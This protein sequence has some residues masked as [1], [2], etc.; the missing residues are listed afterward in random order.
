[1]SK[2]EIT[3]PSKLHGEITVLGAKNAA[4]KMIAA[5][6]LISGKV[7]LE[8]VPDILDIKTIVDILTEN[9][10]KITRSEHTLEI[11]TTNLLESDPNP[12][13]VKKMRGSIVLI[14][15]YLARFGK[16]SIPHPG[17]CVIGSRPIDIHLKAFR[18]LGT[19]ISENNDFYTLKINKI[20]GGH[21]KFEKISVTAT[22]N[23]LMA[24]VLSH[25]KTKI[26]NAAR[27][28]EIVDLANFL[29][30]TGAKITGA[31][32]EEIVIDGEQK[33]HGLTYK[34]IPDRIEAGTFATLGVVTNST[35]K[36]T[37]CEPKHLDAFFDKLKDIGAS[38]VLGSDFIQINQHEKLKS[39]NIETHEYP[40][41][42]TDLQAPFGLLLTQ[43]EGI[44]EIKENIHD[45]RLGY[46]DELEKMGAKVKKID[47]KHALVTG[48][49]D[50]HG[51]QIKSLDLRAGATMILAAFIAS[52]QTDIS[53][54]E[55]V[56][57][58]YE[59]IENRLK[60]LG[61]KIERIS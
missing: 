36:I 28:P 54:I 35:I 10:A 39:T 16:I 15:P 60:K 55:V 22:E 6:V 40:G 8:N 24:A 34:V 25:G 26:T 31:G 49:T 13:L 41:F 29:N 47:H 30:S 17:G 32:T 20:T 57:R 19:Q 3:G 27:E 9:G 37:N 61:A 44:G 2:F 21:I 38:F 42:P 23:V 11:D 56:D 4:M 12:K 18:D 59:N 48:K 53:D 52:G 45:N 58:G 7:V 33:L 1:M 43:C 50:L 14:G 5:S 46:L 51:A